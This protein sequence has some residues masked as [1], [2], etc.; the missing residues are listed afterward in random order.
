ML[1]ATGLTKLLL[2]LS[3]RLMAVHLNLALPCFPGLLFW[4]DAI[5]DGSSSTI[6]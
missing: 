1:A 3:R 4:I 2:L 6:A 5:W